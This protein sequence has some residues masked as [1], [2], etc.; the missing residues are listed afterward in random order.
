[1]QIKEAGLVDQISENTESQ[2]TTAFATRGVVKNGRPLATAA[3][4]PRRPDPL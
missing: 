3:A 1:M 2:M 4:L